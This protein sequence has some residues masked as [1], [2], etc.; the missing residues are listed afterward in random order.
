MTAT[1]SAV[2]S[3]SASRSVRSGRFYCIGWSI[4]N[5][6]WVLYIVGEYKMNHNM[7]LCGCVAM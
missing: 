6:S 7:W 3:V 2:R 5:G 1:L 4:V